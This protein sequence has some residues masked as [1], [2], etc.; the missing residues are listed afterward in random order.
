MNSFLNFSSH[1]LAPIFIHQWVQ[2]LQ[3]TAFP[4]SSPHV[5]MV[6]AVRSC[7]ECVLLVVVNH[8]SKHYPTLLTSSPHVAM[9]TA[10]RIVGVF[11]SPAVLVSPQEVENKCTHQKLS[12]LCYTNVDGNNKQLTMFQKQPINNYYLIPG[13]EMQSKKNALR[14]SGAQLAALFHAIL[15]GLFFSSRMSCLAVRKGLRA[16]SLLWTSDPSGPTFQW[17]LVG[18]V[19]E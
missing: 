4:S 2:I 7:S 11:S 8:C 14:S 15:T 18:Q 13:W 5:T 1:I 10:V 9:V 16:I 6:T 17:T 12:K 3:A 19:A